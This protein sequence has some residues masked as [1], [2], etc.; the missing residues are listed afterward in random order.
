MNVVGLGGGIGASRFW[1]VLVPAVDA[2][3]LTVIVNVADDL[4][5]HGLRVCPDLDA[6]LYA[7]SGRRDD[8]RGWGVRGESWHCMDA[9]RDLGHEVWFNLGDRDLATH[10]LRTG[11]LR[12][13][14]GLATVTARLAAAMD[15]GVTVLPV[16]EHEVTTY[17]ETESGER[18][19]YEEFLVRHGAQPLVQ[20]VEHA[21]LHEA[22]AAPGV[23]D[24]ISAADVIVI[25]PSHPVASV[26]PVLD[27]PGVRDAMH[28]SLARVV[29]VSPIV[30]GIA[31]ADPGEARRALSRERLIAPFGH[32]ATATGVACMYRDL[33]DRFVLDP[34]DE[35]ERSAL[36]DLG[37][38]VVVAPTLVHLGAPPEP[39]LDAVLDE[40]RPPA[41]VTRLP[42]PAAP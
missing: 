14:L 9:M 19:H 11:L 34:A 22:T 33:I 7:L 36:A 17:V 8:Q 20:R 3:D 27:V 37:I 15:V 39:L 30:S 18:L 31:I 38:D 41:A 35:A 40:A 16:T 26:L 6:T 28:E 42:D 13:G 21:G 1:E 29:A 4:W 12:Q 2:A 5:I 32:A 10:L 25:A 24:A 23:L